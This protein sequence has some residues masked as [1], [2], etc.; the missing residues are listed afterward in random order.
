MMMNVL[1]MI[2]SDTQGADYSLVVVA[3]STIQMDE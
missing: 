1:A 2:T 3:I